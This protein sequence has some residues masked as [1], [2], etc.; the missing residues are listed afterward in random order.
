MQPPWQCHCQFKFQFILI[1]AQIARNSN[2]NGHMCVLFNLAF[3]KI[4][5][6]TK[7]LKLHSA[8]TTLSCY[9]SN[10]SIDNFC[11]S[12]FDSNNYYN[13]NCF[14]RPTIEGQGHVM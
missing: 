13:V 6:N 9:C 12:N 8:L 2:K 1:F 14:G 5:L 3:A 11:H 4:N 10:L 7:R